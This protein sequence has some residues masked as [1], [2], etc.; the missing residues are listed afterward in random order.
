MFDAEITLPGQLTGS[1]VSSGRGW[2]FRPGV[3]RIRLAK[4]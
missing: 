4:A 1:F 3:N 2:R